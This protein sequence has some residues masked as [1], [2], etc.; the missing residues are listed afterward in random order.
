MENKKLFATVKTLIYPT[1]S[2]VVTRAL[3]MRSN[4][5]VARFSQR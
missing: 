1:T 2:D 3:F 5:V 4:R